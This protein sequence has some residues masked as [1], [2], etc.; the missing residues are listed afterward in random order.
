MTGW[1]G[2]GCRRYW[3]D[4]PSR[5]DRKRALVKHRSVGGMVMVDLHDFYSAAHLDQLKYWFSSSDVSLQIGVQ[6]GMNKTNNLSNLLFADLWKPLVL[7]SLPLS[8]RASLIAWRKITHLSANSGGHP[9]I[10]LPLAVLKR[11]IPDLSLSIW[12][13]YDIHWVENLLPQGAPCSPEILITYYNLLDQ[14][15]FSP[16]GPFLINLSN[17]FH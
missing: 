16:H 9:G 15:Y 13:R 3:N 17:P 5:S 4:I 14:T 6:K 2:E 1:R 11:L 8:T 12:D 10:K 7:H